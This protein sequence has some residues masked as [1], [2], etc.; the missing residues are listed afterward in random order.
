[1]SRS[2]LDKRDSHHE[3]YADSAYSGENIARLLEK[4]R[5]RNRIHEKGYSNTPL[6]EA[7]LERNRKKSKIRVRVEH[8]FGYMTNTMRGIH[9]RTIGKKRAN[10]LIGLMNL[11]YNLSRYVQLVR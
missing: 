3:L 7:Q 4:K 6:T 10:G 5:I 9:L 1:M 11:T 8:V 2:L